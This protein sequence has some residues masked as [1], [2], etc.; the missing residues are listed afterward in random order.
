MLSWLLSKTNNSYD[1]IFY[2]EFCIT[3]QIIFLWLYVFSFSSTFNVQS[4]SRQNHVEVGMCLKGLTW[5]VE[6]PS[7]CSAWALLFGPSTLPDAWLPHLFQSLFISHVISFITEH[8]LSKLGN[9]LEK[10]SHAVSLKR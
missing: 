5:R 2:L 4:E 7:N 9:F 3:S 10:Y 8:Q 6:C 1:S